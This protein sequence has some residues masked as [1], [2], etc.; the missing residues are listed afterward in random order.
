VVEI[1]AE[2]FKVDA[3]YD[4]IESGDGTFFSYA[5]ISR[6]EHPLARLMEPVVTREAQKKIEG[7][8]AR[9]KSLVEAAP[10]SGP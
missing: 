10:W 4:L 3:R 7:D 6:Y 9:L 2:G 5:C 8:L 1:K